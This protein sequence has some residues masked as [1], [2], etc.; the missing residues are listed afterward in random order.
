MNILR[1]LIEETP[2]DIKKAIDNLYHLRFYLQN[3]IIFI[4]ILI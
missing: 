2:E 4:T 1:N 3:R